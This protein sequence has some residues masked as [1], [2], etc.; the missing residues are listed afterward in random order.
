MTGKAKYPLTE[1]KCVRVGGHCYK[2]IPIVHNSIPEI[3]ARICKH[4][5]HGQYL[6]MEEGA[7]W[8]DSES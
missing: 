5:G 8:Q 1:K 7:K 3:H 4:C 6:R 2:D